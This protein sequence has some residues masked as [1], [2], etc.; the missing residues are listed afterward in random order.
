[1]AEGPSE[2][3]MEPAEGEPGKRRRSGRAVLL[4]ALGVARGGARLRARLALASGAAADAVSRRRS[5]RSRRAPPRRPPRRGLVPGLTRGVEAGSEAGERRGAAEGRGR[6]RRRRARRCQ[7]GA[8]AA[9]A[10]NHAGHR[11]QGDAGAGAP[12]PGS[13][14]V[15]VVGDSLEVLSSPYLA[16]SICPVGAADDQRRGRLLEPA[17]LRALPGG[18]RPLAVGDRLR[19][20]HQRQPPLPGDPRRPPAGR[21]RASSATAAWSCRRSTG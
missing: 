2:S 10:R 6:A 19:R 8:D 4:A 9:S 5:A 21:L 3:E 18:L 16:G 1:M 15:L 11:L 20:R 7:R 13:G 12:L 17:D 14:G